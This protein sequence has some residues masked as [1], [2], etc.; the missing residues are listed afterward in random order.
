[1]QINIIYFTSTGNTLWLA[2]QA[3]KIIEQEGHEV[4]LYEV[5]KDGENFLKDECDMYGVFA[6]VWGFLPPDPLWNFLKDKMPEG[7]N[8]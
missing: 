6:P 1:M 8:A 3:K 4:R 2:T 5:I 7:K